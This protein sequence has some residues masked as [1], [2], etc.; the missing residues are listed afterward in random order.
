MRGASA[1]TRSQPTDGERIVIW[2][3]IWS[4]AAAD[5]S[6][7]RM[8]TR[9]GARCQSASMQA[10]AL[11]GRADK[12][13]YRLGDIAPNE[14]LPGSVAV[15]RLSRAILGNTPGLR[16]VLADH[17]HGEVP[18]FLLLTPHERALLS[19]TNDAA[20]DKPGR[21]PALA[22]IKRHSFSVYLDNMKHFKRGAHL[23]HCRGEG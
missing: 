18:N 19:Q 15:E 14:M 23:R 20:V 22:K 6:A 7:E 12:L 9:D 4:G 16:P 1:L 3:E 17:H 11:T 8:E 2:L 5:A 13:L 10:F 21:S